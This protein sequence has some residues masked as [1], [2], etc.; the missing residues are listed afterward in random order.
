MFAV[1]KLSTRT[2]SNAGSSGKN[3]SGK[4]GIIS[5]SAYRSANLM[6]NRVRCITMVTWFPKKK[7]EKSFRDAIQ[8]LRIK[9]AQ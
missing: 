6:E 4:S 7:S 2:S 5:I 3:F 9:L 8:S 1:E